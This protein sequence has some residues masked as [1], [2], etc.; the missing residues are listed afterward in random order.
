MSF[1]FKYIYFLTVILSVFQIYI[2]NISGIVLSLYFILSYFLFFGLISDKIRKIDLYTFSYIYLL[3]STILAVFWSPDV[4][5]SYRSFLFILSG[6]FIFLYTRKIVTKDS[7]FVAE[8]LKFLCISISF[9]SILIVVFFLNPNIEAIFLQSNIAKIFI[10]NG[11][12]SQYQFDLGNNVTDPN[13]AGGF[14]LN[15]NSSAIL[16]EIGFYLSLIL[17]K[18]N[19]FKNYILFAI[20]NF[21]GIVFTGSKSA[22]FLSIFSYFISYIIFTL[23]FQKTTLFIKQLYFLLSFLLIGLILIVFSFISDTYIYSDGVVNAERR[24]VIFEFAY[25]KFLENP[26]LGLGFGGWEEAFY[27]YGEGLKAYA[28]SGNMPAHNYFIISWANG[29]F[30]LL[31]ASVLFYFIIAHVSRRLYKTEGKNIAILFFSIFICVLFHS[32]VDNVLI[33]EEVHYAGIFA[34]LIAWAAYSTKK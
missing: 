6:F 28:L 9:N 17:G 20:L 26:L 13:K 33:Y 27:S 19:K 16:S 3:F 18:L 24:K 12:L 31:L 2:L 11:S 8:V 32:F 7:N 22:L 30:L 4:Y 15:G 21:L 34:A 23:F 29:G 10:N 1:N 25:Q 14:F 5:A